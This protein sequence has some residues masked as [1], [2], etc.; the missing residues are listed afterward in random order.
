MSTRPYLFSFWSS[1]DPMPTYIRLCRDT[2]FANLGEAFEIVDLNFDTCADWIPERDQLWQAATPLTEGRSHSMTG[3]HFAQF[4][5]MLRVGLLARFGGLWVDADQIAFAN[6]AY[7]APLLQSHEIIA[8]EEADG[9]VSNPVL[10]ACPDSAFATRLWQQ[11]LARL[12]E[13]AAAGEIGCRWGEMGFRLLNHVW[14][15][16]PPERAFV[17]P[18]G[19]LVSFDT[20]TGPDLFASRQDQDTPLSPLALGLSVFN[21]SIGSTLRAQS[22]QDLRAQNSLFGQALKI[23][24]SGKDGLGDWIMIRS[25]AQLAALDRAPLV[26]A[27]LGERH[28]TRDYNADLKTRLKDRNT[29]LKQIKRTNKRL[30]RRLS[31]LTEPKA[32]DSAEQK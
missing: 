11:I 28:K 21:N 30:K 7:L 23:A 9:L 3:R 10:G 20:A 1:P 27:R 18:F 31:V 32:P 15:D 17:A 26:S 8:P 2:V 13:K 5:G 12:A 22:A 25:S 14:A 24:E 4:T 16:S 6:F 29:K 19:S